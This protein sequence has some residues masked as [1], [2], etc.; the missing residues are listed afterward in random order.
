MR[1]LLAF[2][3][4]AF[5]ASCGPYQVNVNGEVTHKFEIDMTNLERYFRA[6]CENEQAEDVEACM[7]L[8][9][10]QFLEFMVDSGK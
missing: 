1:A 2:I 5:L 9:L 3:L 6:L 7:N 4:V 8:K 10:A